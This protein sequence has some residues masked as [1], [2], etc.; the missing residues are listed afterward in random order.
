MRKSAQYRASS[1]D[2][3]LTKSLNTISQRSLRK[4]ART[5]RGRKKSTLDGM[6][7]ELEGQ[8]VHN[9]EKKCTIK[10]NFKELF[11]TVLN[12]LNPKVNKPVSGL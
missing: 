11:A 3:M 2:M 8:R 7:E 1:Y 6:M 10:K 12:P 4:K 5:G 9:K